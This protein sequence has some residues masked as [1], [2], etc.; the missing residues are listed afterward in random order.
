[1]F[2]V[3]TLLTSSETYCKFK[4]YKPYVQIHILVIKP[5]VGKLKSGCKSTFFL[6]Y[7]Y[8]FFSEKDVSSSK[9][10]ITGN[11]NKIIKITW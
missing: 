6:F 3:A 10:S 11:C 1:M 8:Y 9:A 5:N 4:N 7:Y 2:P